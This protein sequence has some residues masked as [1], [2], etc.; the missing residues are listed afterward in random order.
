MSISHMPSPA[1][2]NSF[3]RRRVLLVSPHFPPVNAPD[4]QRLRIA[5]PYFQS[6]GWEVTVLTVAPNESAHS[7]D[8]YLSQVL[9]DHVEIVTVSASPARLTRKIGLGNL[10]LRCWPYLNQAGQALLRQRSYDLVFFSTAMFPVLTLGPIWFKRFNVPYIVDFQDPWR[11]D[12]AQQDHR[13]KQR[14]GGRV[15]YAMD[16]LLAQLLE[17]MALSR[18]SHIVS[19]SPDYPKILQQRYAWLRSEM[20]TVLPF[21]APTHDYIQLPQLNITQSIFDSQDGCRHWVYVGRGGGDMEIALNLLFKGIYQQRMRSPD[22]WQ[23]IKLHFVGTSYDRSAQAKP[24]EALAQQHGVADIVS[25]H[26]Q[27]IP[28]FEAQQ[29]LVDSDAILL[30]GSEDPSYSASKLYTAILAKRPLL[31]IFHQRSLVV[32]IIRRC[33]AGDVVTF[34]ERTEVL[35][36]PILAAID[37]LVTLPKGAQAPTQWTEFSAYSAEHMTKRLCQCFDM[38]VS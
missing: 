14:P 7:Q 34:N 37:K 31:A 3:N 19:V 21:G 11:V 25:E 8:A 28:Y 1:V 4:H 22:L 15:E 17:P 10:G 23:K 27:R 6:L 9:P 2:S 18:V 16:K 36:E 33:K 32:D 24:I 5:L 13:T 29:V 38:A 26:P 12:R 20:F 35:S 30:V